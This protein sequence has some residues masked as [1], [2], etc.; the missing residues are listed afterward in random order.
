M[1]R[2]AT[3]RP[4]PDGLLAHRVDH[5]A[6]R[7]DRDEPEADQGQD[8][9]ELTHPGGVRPVSHRATRDASTPRSSAR[10]R[11]DTSRRRRTRRTS[12]PA[13][14]GPTSPTSRQVRRR[15]GLVLSPRASS[16]PT[17]SSSMFVPRRPVREDQENRGHRQH[18]RLRPRSTGRCRRGPAGALR[19]ASPT[20]QVT[21]P[22]SPRA[23]MGPAVPR[24]QVVGAEGAGTRDFA[25]WHHGKPSP[26]APT[27]S[28][29]P[30]P[31]PVRSGR[32][33]CRRGGRPRRGGGRRRC[34]RARRCGRSSP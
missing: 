12:P 26:V 33:S 32:R 25:V 18:A 34:R 13:V 29:S 28:T 8:G 17:R 1:G 27:G 7:I 14:C 11:C 31:A 5:L 9:F 30:G 24:T 2:V 10:P 20:T 19:P 15:R 21:P 3:T 6:L 23:R 22:A 16:S 4:V